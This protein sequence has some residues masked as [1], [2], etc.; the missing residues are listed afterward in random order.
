MNKQAHLTAD[1]SKVAA[2]QA[3]LLIEFARTQCGSHLEML[4][5]LLT[6]FTTVAMAHGCCRQAAASALLRTGGWLL[7]DPQQQAHHQSLH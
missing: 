1:D 5:A 2:R 6:A 7:A 3:E 4:Q